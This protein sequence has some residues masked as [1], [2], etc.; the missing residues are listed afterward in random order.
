MSHYRIDPVSLRAYKDGRDLN[1]TYTELRV[2]SYL[3]SVDGATV[4]IK[5]IETAVWGEVRRERYSNIV[6]VYFKYLRDKG[7]EIESVGYGNGCA[8]FRLLNDEEVTP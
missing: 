3:L 4:R 7:V 2:L 1:L 6:S 5:E 8:G